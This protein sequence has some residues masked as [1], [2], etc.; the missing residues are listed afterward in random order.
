MSLATERR[1]GGRKRNAMTKSFDTVQCV[2]RLAY[3]RTRGGKKKGKSG[4]NR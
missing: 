4:V 1:D 2:E 3:A